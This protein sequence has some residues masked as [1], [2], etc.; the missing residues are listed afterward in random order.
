VEPQAHSP[1]LQAPYLKRHPRA[2]A[3]PQVTAA[4]FTQN[5]SRPKLSL[6]P[7]PPCFGC[8]CSRCLPLLCLRKLPRKLRC[9]VRI[10]APPVIPCFP[11]FPMRPMARRCPEPHLAAG[12]HLRP[13]SPLPEPL[14]AFLAW[15]SGS[16]AKPER[17]PCPKMRLHVT[18]ANHRHPP[19]HPLAVSAQRHRP[20]A[21]CRFRQLDLDPTG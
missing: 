14:D 17:K 2:L 12:R 18:P 5:P 1:R 15:H 9:G 21:V 13:L 11:H 19:P 3:L 4:A 20:R 7:P 8:H 16:Q 10:V 6:L